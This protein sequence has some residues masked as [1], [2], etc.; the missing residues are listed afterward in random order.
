MDK[1]I[2]G[3]KILRVVD[4]VLMAANAYV[5]ASGLVTGDYFIAAAG[6]GFSLLMLHNINRRN[7]IIK[8]LESGVTGEDKVV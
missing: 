8:Q 1:Q 5:G 6:I 3:Q 7:T 4:A 2:R